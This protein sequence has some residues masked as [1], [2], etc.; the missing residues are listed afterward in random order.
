MAKRDKRAKELAEAPKISTEKRITHQAL[1]S[2]IKEAKGEMACVSTAT[3]ISQECES[4]IIMAP[5]SAQPPAAIEAPTEPTVA[6]SE[7]EAPASQCPALSTP[8]ASSP[9]ETSIDGDDN[10]EFVCM[11]EEEEDK[12]QK[13]TVT[14][15]AEEDLGF[16]LVSNELADVASFSNGE[17]L[18]LAHYA[19]WAYLDLEANLGDS[20]YEVTRFHTPISSGY[21][22]TSP[23]RVVIT[24]KG[25]DTRA[26]L[27]TD[28]QGLGSVCPELLPTGGQI[29]Q[30][31]L[32][33]FR[34]TWPQ[35]LAVLEA[36]ASRQ[37]LAVADL[38]VTVCGHSLGA[39]QATL[40]TLQM[41]HLVAAVDQVR[42]VTF[43][44]PR[45]FSCAG[46]AYFDSL[47]LG[48]RTL[49]VAENDVDPVTMVNLGIVGFKHVGINL[50]VEKPSTV[51]PHLMEGYIA[52]LYALNASTFTPTFNVGTRRA[53]FHACQGLLRFGR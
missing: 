53:I 23:G 52:G 48:A 35:I 14:N 18:E 46:A 27:L 36:H 32:K 13:K 29:H 34:S 6:A 28:F 42:L 10:D 40:A 45:V 4:E 19:S 11:E 8:P 21:V 50:R 3:R 44:S 12:Q 49:R 22:R 37:G 31:F 47:G 24:Y 17:A 41:A 1:A 38:R 43:G 7:P 26:D 33:A 5:A 51:L 30:G 9:P 20:A 15:N 2:L 25:T 16:A 39:A